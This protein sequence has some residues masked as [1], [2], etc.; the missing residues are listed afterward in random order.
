M[1]SVE[2][3]NLFSY[4]S[5][6]RKI[7]VK[8]CG[9][10]TIQDIN[11]CSRADYL[12]FIV[13]VPLSQRNLSINK[14]KML[15]NIA[16]DYAK[17][18]AVTKSLEATK[19]IIDII[20]PD[21]VQLHFQLPT[22]PEEVLSVMEGQKYA[23]CLGV[24]TEKTLN[25]SHLYNEIGKEAE[26]IL[27]ESTQKND[28]NGGKGVVH[29]WNITSKIIQTNIIKKFLIAGGINATN[30]AEALMKTHASGIDIASSIE[31]T[32]GVKSQELVDELFRNIDKYEIN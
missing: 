4:K 11:I 15:I 29:D 10:R 18:V 16:K 20:R 31:N 12:G 28:I 24:S 25:E 21:I 8:L 30:F 1:L 27:I 23:L 6:A 9:L 26:Y 19:K 13:D 14:A 5:K 2:L 17:T 7:I 22:S 32:M 3:S